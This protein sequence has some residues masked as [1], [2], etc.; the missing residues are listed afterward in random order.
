[1]EIFWLLNLDNSKLL[2]SKNNVDI[3]SITSDP[4][5]YRAMKKS[6]SCFYTFGLKY[7]EQKRDKSPGPGDYNIIII[8]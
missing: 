3:S 8:I 1:M 7:K 6:S 4:G 5:V 2:S